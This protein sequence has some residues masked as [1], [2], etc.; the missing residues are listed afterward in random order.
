MTSE[1]LDA[2]LARM[3]KTI[4][5]GWDLALERIER[6]LARLGNPHLTIPPVIHVAGTNGKGSTTATMRAILEAAGKRVHVFTSPHLV[7]FNERIRLGQPGGGKLATDEALVDVLHR[8]EAANAGEAITFWELSTVAAF[9]LY[10]ETPADYTLLEVGLGGRLDSTNVIRE[11]LACVFTPISLDHEKFL[12][13]TVAKIAFEKAGILKRGAVAVSA[14]QVPDAL[15]V[16][17]RQ[18]ARF[19]IRIL[20]GAQDWLVTPENGRLVYQDDR[21]LLDLPPPRLLGRHQYVN[22]GTAIAALRA[23]GIAPDPETIAAGI[24][25]V[26]WPARMQRLGGGPLVDLAV[27]GSEVWLDGGHN[28]GGG[29][30]I[31]ATLADLEDRVARPLFLI[32]G[33]LNTKDPVGYFRPFAGLARH[34]FTVPMTDTPNGRLPEELAEAARAAGLSAEPTASI[35]E[36]IGLISAGWRLEQAPR[37]LICGSL[38]LAGAVLKANGMIPE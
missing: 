16:L 21:G 8:A 12:G 34:V 15:T 32:T 1:T 38:Y 10:A 3:S 17:E 30:V 13:D 6:L 36:A 20:T 4:P 9:M 25:R 31:A 22:T 7:R 29:E 37:I 19:G 28:P 26:D 27:K 11:P 5:D 18:A 24:S 33:M 35:Q 14:P 2:L 23:A